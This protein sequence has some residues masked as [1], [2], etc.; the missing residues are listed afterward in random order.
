MISTQLCSG[1]CSPIYCS[2]QEIQRAYRDE[3]VMPDLS[4][5]A[6]LT[7]YGQFYSHH[8]NVFIISTYLLCVRNYVRLILN[9]DLTFVY[10]HRPFSERRTLSPRDIFLNFFYAICVIQPIIVQM[11]KTLRKPAFLL[12]TRASSCSN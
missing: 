5:L 2:H 7:T 12:F 6:P 1:E 4:A 9:F 8:L 3:S 10:E 11:P